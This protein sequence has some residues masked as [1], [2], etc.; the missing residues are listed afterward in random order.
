M[1]KSCKTGCRKSARKPMSISGSEQPAPVAVT[2]GDPA[3]IG[4]DLVLQL[5]QA[6]PGAPLVALGD[7]EVLQQR[8]TQLGS[9]V[10]LVPWQ[11][12]DPAPRHGQL[13]VPHCPAAPRVAPG[14]ADPARRAG[15]V[16]TLLTAA[17]GRRDA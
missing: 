14:K 13:A 12:G 11:P 2:C 10:A 5:P 6:F 17:R 15:P 3:G 4:P 8:A 9:D 7:L 1:Q 16:A